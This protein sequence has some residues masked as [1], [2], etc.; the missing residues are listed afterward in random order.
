MHPLLFF[1]CKLLKHNSMKKLLYFLIVALALMPLMSKAQSTTTNGPKLDLDENAI[2]YVLE[3]KDEL[4]RIFSMGKSIWG[5]YNDVIIS[6][7][8]KQTN[9]LSEQ[10]VDDDYEGRFAFLSNEN[11]TVNVVRFVANKKT[12]MVECQKA[13]FPVDVKVP[14]K[15]VFETFYS[16][17]MTSYAKSINDYNIQAMYNADRS[18]F[19]IS[20]FYPSKEQKERRVEVAVFDNEGAFLWHESGSIDFYPYV[21]MS[22]IKVALDGTVYVSGSGSYRTKGKDE[23]YVYIVTCSQ[24]GISGYKN[25]TESALEYYGFKRAV[26]PNGEFRLVG[27]KLKNNRGDCKIFTY[28]ATPDGEVDYVEEDAVISPYI[29]GVKYDAENS[30]RMLEGYTPYLFDLIC[31]Q[32]GNLLLVGEMNCRVDLSDWASD[33]SANLSHNIMCAK[34]GADGKLTELNVFPRATMTN[35]LGIWHSSNPVYAFEHDGD[36]YLMYNDHRDNYSGNVTQWKTLYYNRPDQ[37]SVILSKIE[38]N[39]GLSSTI[40]YNAKTKVIDPRMIAMQHNHE[41][42]LKFLQQEDDG[43]YYIL[44]R[45]DD[46]HLEK[47]TIE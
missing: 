21:T 20:M 44:K 10:V 8:D 2:T 29:E 36:V 22:S 32:D 16:F 28:M 4:M 14:K 41:F 37:C 13:S 3:D 33:Q 9:T 18:K 34:V 45:D 15:L 42:F 17:Q 12:M 31:L 25:N 11:T 23:S 39:G 35:E 47:V 30:K 5:G 27:I 43:M 19:A 46:F 7:Y 1:S 40:L 24:Q 38:G 26:L 6:K